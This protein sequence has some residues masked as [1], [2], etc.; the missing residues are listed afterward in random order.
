MP[1]RLWVDSNSNWPTIACSTLAL[2]VTRIITN[3]AHNAFAANNL[4]L[5]A[6]FLN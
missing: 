2:F 4:A 6:H 3:H 5:A 1:T